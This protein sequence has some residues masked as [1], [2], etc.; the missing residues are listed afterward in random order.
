MSNHQQNAPVYSKEDVQCVK[1]ILSGVHKASD[2]GQRDENCEEHGPYISRGTDYF[3]I[4]KVWSKCPVCTAILEKEE[5]EAKKQQ[6]IAQKMAKL[7]SIMYQAGIPKRFE[8]C[9]FEN[10][11][12]ETDEQ[13]QVL[14]VCKSYA[15]R[16]DEMLN[17]GRGLIL[18]GKFG[19]G[20][21]H[22]ACSIARHVI[23][24]HT[25]TFTTAI[26][27][28]RTVASTYKSDDLARKDKIQSAY[29][30]VELLIIDEIGVGFGTDHERE[31]MSEILLDRYQKNLSTILISN[32]P[33]E[34]F[35]E[36]GVTYTGLKDYVGPRVVSRFEDTMKIVKFS[37]NSYRKNIRQT[38]GDDL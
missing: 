1:Q 38:W 10:Y 22:L 3:G 8:D 16:F 11:Q 29:R 30:N 32:A 18:L 13:K 34:G 6:E 35:N 9:D 33:Y 23:K 15:D 27:M 2:L 26:G 20:K 25:V 4:T 17:H 31:V 14:R 21:T 37:W 5:A 19:N 12:A 36:D 28:I 7:H 24:R